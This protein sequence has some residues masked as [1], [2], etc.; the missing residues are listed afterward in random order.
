M[1]VTVTRHGKAVLDING[2]LDFV[3][4]TVIGIIQRRTNKGIDANGQPF[5]PYSDLYSKQLL[6]VGERDNVDL[7]RSGGMLASISE[8]S[9]SVTKDGGVVAIGPGTGTSRHMPLPP[10][11]VFSEDKT[12]EQR[13]K[14]LH[15][16]ETAPKQQTR[17]PPHNV[18]A[19]WHHFGNG[20]LPARPFLGLTPEERRRLAEKLAKLVIKQGQ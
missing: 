18:L 16:W 17:S 11:Y 10:P 14:A 3:A 5:E 9:R 2:A 19:R 20:R 8:R 13:A 12:P 7:Q 15:D 6:A 4:S 1:S